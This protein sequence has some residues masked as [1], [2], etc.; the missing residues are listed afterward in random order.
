M[1]ERTIVSFDYAIKYLLRDPSDHKI[2]SGFLSELLGKKVRVEGILE[3][4]GV[5][6]HKDAKINRLDVKARIGKG[7]MAVFE[8]QYRDLE[9]FFGKVLFDVSKA[10][11]EQI[12]IG[13]RYNVKKVYSV[14][15]AYYD[16]GAE[17]E[18]LFTAKLSGFKGVHYNET[19][20]FAQAYGL[21]RPPRPKTDI[22]PEYFLLLPNK[23]DCEIRSKFD[24][25]MYVL[26]KSAVKGEFTAEGLK[27]AAEKLDVLKM[28][29][30]EQREYERYM[31]NKTVLESE[32][33]TAITKG[34]A[35]G[36]RRGRR[37]GKA[38]GLAEG[39]E[40]GRA[41]GMEKGLA[42]GMEKGLAEGEKRKAAEIAKAMKAAGIDAHT[43][44]KI[45]K[46]SASEIARI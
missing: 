38:E 12:P 4:E 3:S 27:E 18:Y 9:D 36:E 39:M 2:L 20:P 34:E 25:W 37:K 11:V 35:R 21:A 24:E 17:R 10:I 31:R 26:K 14:N 33:D 45:T 5:K 16:V 23:F 1:E 6:S 13:G 43:I 29:L 7:E 44:A 32:F 40:K 15:I 8:I 19:V 41:E 22:H 30:E 42:E 46:L 28:T